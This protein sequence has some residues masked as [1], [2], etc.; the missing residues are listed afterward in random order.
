MPG[1]PSTDLWHCK[2]TCPVH[3]LPPHALPRGLALA[4]MWD[5]QAG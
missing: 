1:M 5:L 4:R 2:P 3:Q